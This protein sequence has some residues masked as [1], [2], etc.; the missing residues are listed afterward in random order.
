MNFHVRLEH[1]A[2]PIGKRYLCS[3]LENLR[4]CVKTLNFS[5]L[6]SLIEEA[7]FQGERLEA[8][9]DSS[10]E[11]RWGM[12]GDLKKA[13]KLKNDSELRAAVERIVEKAE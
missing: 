3:V 1:E 5:I 10:R 12:Y 11:K 13:L 2:P 4:A 6:P 8:G 7:Q 9:L